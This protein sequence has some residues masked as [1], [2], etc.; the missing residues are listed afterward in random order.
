MSR[1]AN[2]PN[3]EDFTPRQALIAAH[4]LMGKKYYEIGYDLGIT[5][6]TVKF[7]VTAIFKKT[8][9]FNRTEFA[10]KYFLKTIH[11]EHAK[12]IDIHYGNFSLSERLKASQSLA[13]PRGYRA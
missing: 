12:L 11:P 13:L 9:S 6:K 3:V 2:C 7:H 8:K 1:C 4:M 5:E 10:L